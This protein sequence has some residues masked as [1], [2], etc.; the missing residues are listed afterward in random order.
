M[1][2]PIIRE[3]V[4]LN[5]VMVHVFKPEDIEAVYRVQGRKPIREGFRMLQKYNDAYNDGIQGIITRYVSL[6]VI[7]VVKIHYI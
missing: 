2:G 3:N 5:F 7:S 1:Y 6:H 4:L